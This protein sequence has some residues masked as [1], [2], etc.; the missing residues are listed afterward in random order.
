MEEND[1]DEGGGHDSGE[2]WLVSYADFI[3]LLFAL[4]VLMYAISNQEGSRRHVILEAMVSE[5]GARPH[6]GGLRPDAG[7][8]QGNKPMAEQ[9]VTV[10]ELGMV[11]E[12]LQQAVAKF[13]NSGVTV[14]MDP[15]G[16]VV[17]LSAARFFASGDDEISP[18]QLPVL[19][20]IVHMIS[21]L[22]NIMEVDGFTDPVP[23]HTARFPD[24][25]E[26]S[27]ARAATV[28]RYIIA[29]S[30]IDAEHLTIAGYGPY[31]PVGDNSTEDGRALNRRVELVIKP[32]E[33]KSEARPSQ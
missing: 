20:V 33:N 30:P 5:L 17:S 4:F 11:M 21:Q 14:T 6:R 10:R 7:G 13:P 26:L 1:E 3:T 9:A 8:A 23:I 19:A 31:R 27:A 29:N 32:M 15:R 22:P 18:N 28:L 24:N 12:H 25:W 2:R 16:L